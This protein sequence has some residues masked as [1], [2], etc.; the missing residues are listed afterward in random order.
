MGNI[1]IFYTKGKAGK[2]TNVVTGCHA[3]HIGYLFR[4]WVYDL[5]LTPRRLRASEY[6]KGQNYT[7]HET[8]VTEEQVKDYWLN[9]Y[10]RLDAKRP[11]GA[12]IWWWI[13]NRL[14]SVGDYALFA[15]RPLYTLLGK[16]VP[17]LD[18]V[19][20]S[21]IINNVE[22]MHGHLTPWPEEDA[23]PSPCDWMRY[24]GQLDPLGERK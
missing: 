2:L 22:R 7:L 8:S 17:N 11:K 3:Y 4:D 14:Y 23:P 18:G 16:Q 12:G 24:F 6:L 20:C 5:H 19:V 1:I 21:E 13:K 9:W 15:L 10:E